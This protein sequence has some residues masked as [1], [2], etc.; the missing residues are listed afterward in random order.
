MGTLFRISLWAALSFAAVGHLNAQWIKQNSGTTSDLT[1]IAILDYST[2]VVVGRSGAILRTTNAGTTWTDV[3]L[4]LSYRGRWNAVSFFDTSWGF[5]AGDESAVFWT[6]NGG[7][8]WMW[9]SLPVMR[10]CLSVLCIGPGECYVG[11][12]SGWVF[13]TSDTGRTWASEKISDWPVR[14]IFRLKGE[15]TV[16]VSGYAITSHSF[17]TEYVIPP[18]SWSEKVM[19]AFENPGSEAYYGLSAG[20]GGPSYVVG[21]SG[22]YYSKPVVFR[23]TLT[24]TTWSDVSP[25]TGQSGIFTGVAAPSAFVVYVCGNGGMMYKST[26]AGG[27]W[28][29]QQLPEPFDFNSICFFDNYH[30]FAV[31]DSGRILYTQSGGLISVEQRSG[32]GTFILFQNYPNPFNP[33]TKVAY[34][35]PADCRVSLEVYDVLGR[36]V[37]TLVYNEVVKM[38]SYEVSFDGS[39]LPSGVYMYVLR[40][41]DF[42]QSRKS[43]LIK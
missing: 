1:D 13:S 4:P 23:R 15:P 33:V 11:T 14:A 19:H 17:C 29:G 24:D 10:T 36:L 20:Q 21:G 37:S 41:G 3:S 31:G 8:W 30:G 35:L 16:G 40:A 28:K 39:G 5:V 34:Q 26:D 9:R 42:I 2:A 32:P 27:S 6:S 43:M 22:D 7:R 18:P 38:A 12:D 25:V